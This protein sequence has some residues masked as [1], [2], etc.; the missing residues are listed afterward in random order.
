MWEGTEGD[1]VR[2]RFLNLVL[3]LSIGLLG[4]G[5]AD[6]L[7]IRMMGRA[8]IDTPT[9][10]TTPNGTFSPEGLPRLPAFLAYFGGLFLLM[11][12]WNQ[13]DPLRTGRF[14][15]WTTFLTLAVAF[16]WQAFWPFPQPWSVVVPA[17]MS[18]AIQLSS[19]W[20][21]ASDRAQMRKLLDA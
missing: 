5:L 18:I 19:T 10:W 11:R 20:L 12:W 1:E 9:V 4:Y 14:S 15:V 2:R 8:I 13:A 21:S 7:G 3:G 16:I 6:F 17:T